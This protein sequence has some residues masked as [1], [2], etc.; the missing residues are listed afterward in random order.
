MCLSRSPDRPGPSFKRNHK[1]ASSL[2]TETDSPEN[3]ELK[4]AN[5]CGFIHRK[6]LSNSLKT[7]VGG[8]LL[9]LHTLNHRSLHDHLKWFTQKCT[10]HPRRGSHQRKRKKA[11]SPIHPIQFWSRTVWIQTG[12]CHFPWRDRDRDCRSQRERYPPWDQLPQQRTMIWHPDRL[13]HRS[14]SLLYNE[15]LVHLLTMWS[16]SQHEC[17]SRLV[18]ADPSRI[19]ILLVL[20]QQRAIPGIGIFPALLPHWNEKC[21]IF[22]GQFPSFSITLANLHFGLFPYVNDRF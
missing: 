20:I 19:R 15:L 7:K 9:Q 17:W 21:V 5:V 22:K 1:S 18:D 11:D 12:Y 4:R 13:K 10:S 3:S 8:G 2:S 16:S 14:R 6:L